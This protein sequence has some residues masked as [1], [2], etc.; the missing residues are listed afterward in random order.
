[1]IKDKQKGIMNAP[2]VIVTGEYA[3]KGTNAQLKKAQANRR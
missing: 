1:V 3:R 2:G